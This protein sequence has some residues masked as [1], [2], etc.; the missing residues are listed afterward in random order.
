MAGWVWVGGVVLSIVFGCSASDEGSGGNPSTG[1]TDA[2]SVGGA[3]TGGTSGASTGG[4]STGGA[5]ASGGGGAGGSG[6]SSVGG[7]SGGANCLPTLDELG[8][9]Y[10]NTTAK[11]V[12][13]A[14]H[15]E[16]P[17]NGILIA[18]GQNE[19]PT[20]DPI[21]CDFVLRLWQ[22]ADVLKA[23]GFVR[24]GTLGSY[25]YRCCCYWSEENYCRGPN[26]PE[27]DCSQAPWQGF[28]T[29]S[30]GRAVDIRWLE[31][32]DG[33]VYDVNDPT[34]FV[35]S[36]AD[37]CEQ[38]LAQQTGISQELYSLV[39]ELSQKQVFG[40]ILTPNYNSVHRNHFH[41]DIGESGEPGSYYVNS[42][43]HGLVDSAACGD[44]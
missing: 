34:H 5:S 27:P 10:S 14:V 15:L 42:A 16:G 23:R 39:C 33:T 4:T 18:D 31:K 7:F 37:T 30:W 11:G 40:T 44:D 12:V 6:A 28:S 13:D 1:G 41:C 20:N 26:D 9:A 2:G 17:L 22:L 25:C 24:V 36:S 21:A 35:M 43:P 38:A 19:E 3:Q 32:S 29:H 8:V